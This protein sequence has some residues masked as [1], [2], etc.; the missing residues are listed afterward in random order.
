[1]DLV[2]NTHLVDITE[3]CNPKNPKTKVLGKAEFLNPG[4]SMKDRIVANIFNKAEEDG[5]LK[6]G[7]RPLD[8]NSLN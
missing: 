5:T 3:V 4:Y 8:S 2:G 6:Q 1:M 7:E